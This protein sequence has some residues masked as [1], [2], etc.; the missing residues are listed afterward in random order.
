MIS[1]ST[2][3]EPMALEELFGY[4]LHHEMHL[5]QLATIMEVNLPY[6]NFF[7]RNSN[8]LSCGQTPSITNLFMAMEVVEVV[9]IVMETQ[10]SLLLTL[11]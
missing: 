6:A 4:L 3:F 9:G 2:R 10:L 11:L 8:N 5:E 1:V 7:I